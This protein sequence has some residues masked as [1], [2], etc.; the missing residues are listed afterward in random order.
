[1]CKRVGFDANAAMKRSRSKPADKASW[2][3]LGIEDRAG[4][5]IFPESLSTDRM[6]ARLAGR[7]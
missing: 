2:I 7:E 3:S 6:L 5:P 1:M 4:N